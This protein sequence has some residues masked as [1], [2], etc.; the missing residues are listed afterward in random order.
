MLDD[1]LIFVVKFIKQFWFSKF[2]FQDFQ[3]FEELVFL[4][5]STH[6]DSQICRREILLR[7]FNSFI[8][9][10]E[11]STIQTEMH[12]VGWY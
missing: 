9:L 5:S 4:L 6:I 10:I 12:N 7:L 11:E 8:F 2:S 3:E 1:V